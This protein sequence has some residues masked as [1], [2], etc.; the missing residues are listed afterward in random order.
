MIYYVCKS[1][2]Y[3]ISVILTYISFPHIQHLLLTFSHKKSSMLQP[4]FTDDEIVWKVLFNTHFHHFPTQNL[5]NNTT[6]FANPEFAKKVAVFNT[7]FHSKSSK[8]WH[9][10]KNPTIAWKVVNPHIQCS[11]L[12]FYTQD[13]RMIATPIFQLKSTKLFSQILT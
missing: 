1:T 5:Q 13:H 9:F 6:F 8:L 11:F 4:C 7:Y 2:R 12:T 3:T 10:F